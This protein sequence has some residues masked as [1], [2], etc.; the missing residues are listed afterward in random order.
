MAQLTPCDKDVH[1]SSVFSLLTLAD[2][3]ND[4][5]VIRK[6]LLKTARLC[7]VAEVCGIKGEEERR[8][9]SPLWGT[10]VASDTQCCKHTYY[11]QS[12]R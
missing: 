8:E 3:S 1:H 2:T 5:R 11:G 12:V 6:L 10:G 9:D 7:L 4:S